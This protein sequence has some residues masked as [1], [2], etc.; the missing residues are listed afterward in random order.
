MMVEYPSFSKD[1]DCEMVKRKKE[2]PNQKP[3]GR[4]REFTVNSLF[5]KLDLSFPFHSIF[6]HCANGVFQRYCLFPPSVLD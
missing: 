4:A 1:V 3:F 6:N 5:S 2:R